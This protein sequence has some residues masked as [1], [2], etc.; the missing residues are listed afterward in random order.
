M[1]PNTP[2]LRGA[3]RLMGWGA[4]SGLGARWGERWCDRMVA[5]GHAAVLLLALVFSLLLSPLLSL[6]HPVV[7]PGH[8][9]APMVAPSAN[10][11]E[12]LAELSPFDRLFG[13][14]TEGS[15]AC[16]LLDHSGA[17]DGL[18]PQD[19]VALLDL[20]LLLW[21]GRPIPTCATGRVAFFQAR[22]PPEFL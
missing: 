9:E 3:V 16:Q 12:A 7:H 11:Q 18:L 22:G 17:P 6:M 2:S 20:P 19:V 4:H 13:S 15:Q 14:H 8:G 1:Q 10:G 5:R 21:L